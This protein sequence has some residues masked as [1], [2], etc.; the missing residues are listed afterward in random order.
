MAGDSSGPFG[1]ACGG[2]AGDIPYGGQYVYGMPC[3]GWSG[4]MKNA[5]DAILYIYL[6]FP[7]DYLISNSSSFCKKVIL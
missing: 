7:V 5:G 4:E 1:A 6:S 2:S 3:H